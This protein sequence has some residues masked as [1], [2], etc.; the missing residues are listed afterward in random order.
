LQKK[1]PWVQRKHWAFGKILNG[2][3]NLVERQPLKLD[4]AGSKRLFR[5]SSMTRQRRVGLCK[6]KDLWKKKG[7]RNNYKKKP[8]KILP[9]PYLLKLGIWLIC[10]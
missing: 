1:G 2:L 4:A 8:A 10:H 5:S 7:I 6:E 9:S 3:N